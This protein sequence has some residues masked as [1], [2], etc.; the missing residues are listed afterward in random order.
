MFYSFDYQSTVFRF[1]FLQSRS[2]F[3]LLS[4]DNIVYNVQIVTSLVKTTK[5]TYLAGRFDLITLTKG[6]TKFSLL[7]FSRTRGINKSIQ[8][9]YSTNNSKL[10]SQTSTKTTGIIPVKDTKTKERS[11]TT[12]NKVLTSLYTKHISRKFVCN[13]E[14][15]RAIEK[16]GEL[17]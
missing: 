16:R 15:K 13:T 3:T 5:T 10:L 17:I 2:S 8:F 4:L 1:Y 9:N 12:L 14:S 7:T 11:V 6:M